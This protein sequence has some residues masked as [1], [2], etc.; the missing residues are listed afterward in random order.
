MQDS[1]AH[2]LAFARHMICMFR[3]GVARSSVYRNIAGHSSDMF[4]HLRSTSSFENA[5][6][7]PD[8]KQSQDPACD[9][10][11]AVHVKVENDKAL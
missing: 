6:T 1:E 9:G 5:F 4:D 2:A 10:V 7:S 11:E 3:R 8:A